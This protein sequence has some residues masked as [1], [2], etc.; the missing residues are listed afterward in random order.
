MFFP[1]HLPQVHDNTEKNSCR[2]LETFKLFVVFLVNLQID[3]VILKRIAR[4][5]LQNTRRNASSR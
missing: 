2:R 5:P 1:C 3:A 4:H